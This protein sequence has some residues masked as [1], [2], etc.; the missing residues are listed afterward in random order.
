ML[1]GSAYHRFANQEFV[2]SRNCIYFFNQKDDYDVEVL[3]AGES[4][5]V[6]FT[7]YEEIK[8]DSFCI[9][10]E[11]PDEVIALLQKAEHLI[12]VSGNGDLSLLATVYKLCE[13]I[14]RARQKV[15][16]P[17]DTRMY[18]AKD[19]IDTHLGDRKCLAR[20]VEESGICARRFNDLFKGNFGVTPNRYVTYRRIE[21]AKTML[22][23]PS[24]T[25][26]E[27]ADLCG[28]SDVY[29]FSKVFKQI[30][31]IPPSK[32]R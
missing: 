19:Y 11:H 31:G 15:Y 21:N 20:A 30:C 10:V 1:N 23:I 28:F 12:Q 24:L 5:S 13:V 22:E 16:F 26:S 27:I 18:A 17:K 2:L 29:Y 8:T 32:W 9:P 4:F 6:H 14:S 3:E 25:V 7:T